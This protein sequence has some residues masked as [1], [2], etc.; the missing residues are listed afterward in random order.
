[1]QTKSG[2][3]KWIAERGR[4]VE[5]DEHS[6]A[7]RATGACWDITWRKH[8]EDVMREHQALL[9]QK[10]D[11][12][13]SELSKA[14]EEL[15]SAAFDSGRAQVSAM[16]LHNI[17]N[18]V[19]P[20]KVSIEG[21][22]EKKQEDIVRYL[23][24]CYWDLAAHAEDIQCY[25]QDDDRGREVFALM[26]NLVDALK[27]QDAERKEKLKRMDEAITYIAEIL[28]L[29]QTYVAK[30]QG[31]KERTKINT[32][33][34]D[35]IR[36][37]SG[38]LE[39]RGIAVKYNLDKGM[40]MVKIEKNKLMQVLVNLIKNSYE[41]ID[42]RQGSPGGNV[43]VVKSFGNEE[44]LGFEITDTGVG[45]DAE[46]IERVIAKGESSKGSTGFGL[47]Y[48]RM[49]AEAN[50]GTLTITSPGKGK[51]AS[52]RVCFETQLRKAA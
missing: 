33:I 21:L 29:Q 32:L 25:V 20:L 8:A 17:G 9:K 7:L 13:T 2:D 28:S 6:R 19:T 35:A 34:S 40:P 31:A 23:D 43:I 16:V 46:E 37:Q 39:K 5:R 18:A 45:M 51:G 42:Q 41:A 22:R 3:W 36:M 14:Q 48:C 52:V 30:G 27:E 11:E 4:V 47:R 26:G 1:M 15:A 38:A 50:H 44:Q 24:E 49:F 12:R 10:V